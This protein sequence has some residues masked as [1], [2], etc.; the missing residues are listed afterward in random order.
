MLFT[1]VASELALESRIVLPPQGTQLYHATWRNIDVLLREA[2]DPFDRR[3]PGHDRSAATH[4]PHAANRQPVR[5]FT[6]LSEGERIVERG[7]VRPIE[8]DGGLAR[9][10]TAIGA[11]QYSIPPDGSP[12]TIDC[13]RFLGSAPKRPF[14]PV[15]LFRW[16]NYRDYGTGVAG[17]LFVHL[18]TGLHF[19]TGSKG[20]N[21]VYTTG[22]LRF[23]KDG[24]DVPDVMLALPDYPG[25][26]VQL[27]VNFVSGT[28]A[29]SA[30]MKFVGG[31]GHHHHFHH[32]PHSGAA[33]T[34]DGTRLYH[35]YISRGRSERFSAAVSQTVSADAGQR[36]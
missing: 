8:Y 17:D 11:W 30:G 9:S 6:G 18:L 5:K 31:E 21:R 15:R 27:K 22:G 23:W 24:R 7:R 29:E 19:A 32:P 13:D 26:T 10:N 34:R 28:P 36:R 3:R 25:F 35:R 4:R 20:P 1:F 33:S 12:A 16:R 14:E 2:D